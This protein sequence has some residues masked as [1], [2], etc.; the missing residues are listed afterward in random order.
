MNPLIALGAI[1]GGTGLI[2]SI[3]GGG[4]ARKAQKAL[5]KLQTP[6]YTSARSILDYYNQALARYNVNPYSSNLYK[7]QQQQGQRGLA[8][9]LSV[10]REGGNTNARLSTLLQGYND[11]LLR[12]G[13]QA[14]QL[15]NQKFSQLGQAT[16]MEAG[17]RRQEFNINKMLPYQKKFSILAQKA[18][19][20]NQMAN[21]GLSNIF[22]GLNTMATKYILD[23]HYG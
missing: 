9:A 20:G 1:Q 14:E 4:K 13:T 6:T 18:S 2:Q 23:K 7:Q 17:E 19:G 11:N 8:T 21:A 5:E 10:A 3:F 15:Q 22:G 16:N 12:A